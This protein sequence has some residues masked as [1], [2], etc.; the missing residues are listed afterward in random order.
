M[1]P[2]ENSSP[3]VSGLPAQAKRRKNALRRRAWDIL[4]YGLISLAGFT[5]I[6]ALLAIF[7]YLFSEVLPLLKP[8]S[9]EFRPLDPVAQLQDKLHTPAPKSAALHAPDQPHALLNSAHL[10]PG[11]QAD[12]QLIDAAQRYAIL[13][14]E[15]GEVCL[16]SLQSSQANCSKRLSVTDR[17]V[18][19][20]AMVWLAGQ[21]S[22][23][24]GD[25]AGQLKQWFL[26]ADA[27]GQVRLSWIKPFATRAAAIVSI[28]PEH[29]R[30]GF[31]VLDA[32][33]ELS[34]FY[35][36]LSRPLWQ[37]KAPSLL[38]PLSTITTLQFT[39]NNA[40]LWLYAHEQP[41]GYFDINNKHPEIS[42][43]T[44]WQKVWYESWQQ[45]E[46][47]WQSSS[48]AELYQGKYSLVPLTFG[49]LKAAFYA[50]LFAVPLAILAAIYSVCFLA[51]P[52]RSRLSQL[53]ELL[54][55]FP[56]VIIGFLAA[57]WLAP[58]LERHL[59]AF[60]VFFLLTPLL[61]FGLA[62]CWP[63]LPKGLQQPIGSLYTLGIMLLVLLI[64]AGI[65]L[66][67]SNGIEQAIL[68]EQFHFWLNQQGVAY[69]QRNALVVGVAMGF[70]TLPIVYSLSY[71]ALAQIPRQLT[72]GAYALGANQWQVVQRIMLPVAAP[73]IIAACMLGL[74]RAIGETMII[75]MAT[76]NNPITNFNLFEG[77]RSLTAT[78]AIELPEA[79]VNSSH[80]RVLFLVAILLFIF[81][82]TCNTLADL[83]RQRLRQKLKR[84]ES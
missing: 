21:Q 28:R 72:L 59:L 81:T 33:G 30:S 47:V 64:S 15:N 7:L 9:A 61:V 17:T 79:A 3:R 55:L 4:W 54:A 75:L 1:I 57:I 66:A 77:L 8:V 40:Q 23:I 45:P 76:G 42:W 63:W 26:L 20:T 78:L 50:M 74:T 67:L 58:A 2:R 83:V 38:A 12:F 53:I 82:F 43:R 35:S 62:K 22:V 60:L 73:G 68:G 6:A 65:A 46:Y 56:T 80:Y 34:V 48:G 52:L 37:G 84:L 13:A 11:F 10:E 69:Q 71:D 31:A 5:V 70:A 19:L 24:T 39:A 32:N 41:V 29:G 36:T 25:S 27:Q 49:T 51:E 44:L 14:K 18:T 16:M